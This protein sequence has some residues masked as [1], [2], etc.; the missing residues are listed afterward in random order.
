MQFS[1][2]IG[3]PVLA[4]VS[5]DLTDMQIIAIWTVISF[6][7]SLIIILFIMKPDIK[8]V[9]YRNKMSTG[10]LIMWAILGVFLAL[11]AQ[12]IASIIEI[13]IFNIKPGSENTQ[14]LMDIARA[15]PVFILIPIIFAP[16]LEE[17]I[18][19][20]I[21]FGSIY[22]RT[23]FIVAAILSALIFAL[24]HTDPKHILVYASMGIVF[25]FL[26]IKTNRIIVP[27]FAHMAMNS[28]VVIM[29]FN[30][31]PDDLEKM[32]KQLDQLQTILTGGLM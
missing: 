17:I 30:V 26:Y 10:K 11:F 15:A 21:I 29:Q 9:Q 5:P 28:L 23:N 14:S 19:R 25:A 6:P 3:V 13:F 32:Q 2:I 7:A 8:Q 22:K 24:V 31:T 1:S 27:I 20:K 4:L 12:Y 16:I 18:F